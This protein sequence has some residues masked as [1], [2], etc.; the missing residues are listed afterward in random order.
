MVQFRYESLINLIDSIDEIEYNLM[1]CREFLIGVL[2]IRDSIKRRETFLR[3][4][5]Y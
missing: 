4:Q 5:L 2:I 1:D 3:A